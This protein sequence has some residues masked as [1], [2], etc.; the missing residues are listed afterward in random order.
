MPRKIRQKE[1]RRNRGN[2]TGWNRW[3][4]KRKDSLNSNLIR[5]VCSIG[6]RDDGVKKK[7]IAEEAYVRIVQISI[8]QTPEIS[9]NKMDLRELPGEELHVWDTGTRQRSANFE[10]RHTL[11]RWSG[12][13]VGAT[14]LGSKPLYE[15]NAVLKENND[16]LASH[17]NDLGRQ[18]HNKTRH[19]LRARTSA[20]KLH[21]KLRADLVRSEHARAVQAGRL[22]CRKADGIKKALRDGKAES[23]KHWMKGKGGIFT[24]KSRE[25]FRDQVALKVPAA[26]VDPVIRTVGRGLGRDVQDSVSMCEINRVVEGRRNCVGF[27]GYGRN[28]RE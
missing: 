25:M 15:G 27:A 9:R 6:G 10:L 28:T 8:E 12:T 17:A 14:S 5:G 16:G 22:E 7:E 26:N 2:G 4:E 3:V 24:E 13:F 18:L 20:D 21:A 19:T 1:L 11:G 23:K